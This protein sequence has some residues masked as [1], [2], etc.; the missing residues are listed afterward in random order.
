LLKNKS[1]APCTP[2]ELT[3]D[4]RSGGKFDITIT[5]KI[6]IFMKKL[7]N[8]GV[9]TLVLLMVSCTKSIQEPNLTE[10]SKNSANLT[11]IQASMVNPNE[12]IKSISSVGFDGDMLV[13]QSGSHFTQVMQCLAEQVDDHE[14]NFENQIISM[15]DDQAND[16]A[17]SL[18]YD[19]DQPLINFENNL[20]FY[21]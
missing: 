8:L 16:Y 9:I 11:T 5:T 19:E 3:H 14:D 12:C 18:N 20:G 21:Y 7:F 10:M 2:D 17:H 15:T 1:G 4:L 13:F 6:R